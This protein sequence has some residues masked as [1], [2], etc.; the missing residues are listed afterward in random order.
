[1][2]SPCAYDLLHLLPSLTVNA[3][4]EPVAKGGTVK[5]AGTLRVKKSGTWRPA[6]G[7]TVVVRFDPA[8]SRAPYTVKKVTT[9]SKGAYSLKRTQKRSGTWV[10]IYRGTSTL[11][12]DRATDYVRTYVSGPWNRPGPDLDCSDVRKTVW[13]GSTDYHRLDADGDGWGCDSWG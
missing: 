10:V 11:R 6:K 8:G 4:P 5:V 13:V 12:A 2:R 1:M 7:R 9:N 3:K